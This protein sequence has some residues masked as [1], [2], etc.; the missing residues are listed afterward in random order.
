MPCS[1]APDRPTFADVKDAALRLRGHAVRTPLVESAR[2]NEQ[3]G[4]RLLVK[5]EMLQ[6]T[7]AFKFRGAYNRISRI[8]EAARPRGVVAYTRWRGPGGSSPS[9]RAIT[10]RAWRRRRVYSGSRP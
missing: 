4:G 1:P 5:A 3:L 8:D 2:L 7:G 6:R 10:P 9:H